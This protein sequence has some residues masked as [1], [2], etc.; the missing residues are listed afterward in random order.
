MN[1]FKWTNNVIYFITQHDWQSN[2]KWALL[3]WPHSKG[4]LSKRSTS[5]GTSCLFP[6]CAHR[7][8]AECSEEEMT[9]AH[10]SLRLQ[11]KMS[12]FWPALVR[13]GHGNWWRIAAKF[14]W[15]ITLQPQFFHWM[16]IHSLYLWHQSRIWQV[17][18]IPELA[19]GQLYLS[20]LWHFV[21]FIKIHNNSQMFLIVIWMHVY[22]C[23][24]CEGQEDVP[25]CSSL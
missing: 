13:C 19:I 9:E 24:C 7:P 4:L 15:I 11:R 8:G 25:W 12:L 21:F 10:F 5:T 20:L 14:F 1:N 17:A 18:I 6:I 2:L 16:I 22:S 23:P 3:C